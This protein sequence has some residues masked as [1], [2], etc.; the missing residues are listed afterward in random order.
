MAKLRGRASCFSQITNH[1]L[2]ITKRGGGEA[3]GRACRA[4]GWRRPPDAILVFR[5]ALLLQEEGKCMLLF[6]AG[7]SGQSE[8]IATPRPA[9]VTSACRYF[10]HRSRRAKKCSI[11]WE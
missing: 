7:N 3:G 1:E 5:L 8:R 2:Q 4:I 9:F 6:A 11:G 10:E